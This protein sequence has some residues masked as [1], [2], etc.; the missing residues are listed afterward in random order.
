M[1]KKK[2]LLIAQEMEPYTG[3]SEIAEIANRLPL[4]LNDNKCEIRILM[5]RFGTINERRHRLHEVVRLSGMN[6]I[7]NDDDFPLIIKVASLPNSRIQVYFL[8]NEEVLKRI[9]AGEFVEWE[10]VYPGTFYGT[11]KKEVERLWQL[12]KDVVFDVDVQGALHIKNIY[13]EQTLAIFVK[14]PSK[15]V[16]CNR[17]MAR[18]TENEETLKERINKAEEELKFENKFDY[19]LVNDVLET[20]VKEAESVVRTWLSAS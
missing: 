1:T 18:Q 9:K 3:L 8:D 10:E 17:L 7:V 4:F 14:P 5:P 19:V 11:L 13:P 12:N 16:L 20:A 15:D 6:I 2:I